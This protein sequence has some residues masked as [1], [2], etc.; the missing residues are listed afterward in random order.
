[1]GLD[2]GRMTVEQLLDLA[3]VNVLAAADHHV[4]DAAD[5][6]AVAVLV[7]RRQVATVP[8]NSIFI[9]FLVDIKQFVRKK[10]PGL[11]ALGFH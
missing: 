6:A 10:K 5:D 2:D 8:E 4:L 11:A 3:R 9:T 7:Q 1:M